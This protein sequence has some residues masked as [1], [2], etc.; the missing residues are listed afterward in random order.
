MIRKPVF[1]R[2]IGLIGLYGGVFVVLVMIQ[3]AKQGGF[4]QQVGSLLITGQYR[5]PEN[6]EAN[7]EAAANVG[8]YPL[9][10]GAKVFFGG[11]EFFMTGGDK[12]ESLILID[13]GGRKT[14]V[15]P[16]YMTIS[17]ETAG[18]HLP[19]GNELLFF[20]QY[21]GG[22][23]ELRISG[24]FA[25]GAV[26]ISL[27]YKPLRSSRV[28]EGEDDQLVVTA[29]G[30]N[31]TF[32]RAIQDDEPGRLLL[33]AGGASI[34]YR[35]IPEKRA[36]SPT[37]F[38]IPAART[39]QAYNEALIRWRDQNFSL[40]NRVVP[41][42]ND[43]DMVIAYEGEAVRRGN[44]K[45]ALAAVPPA[46]LGGAQRSYES[47]VYLGGMDMAARTFAAAEREKI[48][49]LS[50]QINEKSLDFLREANVFEFFAIRGYTNFMDGGSALIHAIDPA[51][52]ALELTA[53]I[54]EGVVDLWRRRP[55]GDNPFE[56]LVDQSCFIISEG[57]RRCAVPQAPAGSSRQGAEQA[58]P[59]IPGTDMILVFRDGAA[60]IEFN[61]RLGKALLAWAEASGQEDWIALG[62]SLILSCLSLE[63]SFGMIPAG[64]HINEAGE[65]AEGGLARINSARFYRILQPGEYYPR[66][67]DIVPGQNGI[68]AWTA[69]SAISATQN[70][71]ILDIAVTF[72]VGEAHHMIIRGIRPF[73]KLQLYGIDF[74]TDPQF[75]RYDSSGWVYQPQEQILVLKMKHRTAVEH[76][77]IF[78]REEQAAVPERVITP[79]PPR[80]TSPG[81]P[82]APPAVPGEASG[83]EARPAAPVFGGNE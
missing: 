42:Q 26:G 73:A 7:A 43:E 59:G 37:D 35:A 20:T 54:L 52:L 82:A 63:D 65:L 31:Y 6:G 46:F 34:A 40:W 13:A 69:V 67:A 47:S 64:M 83:G 33:R 14:E 68:W 48:S 39:A 62:R 70:D 81:V 5:V 36:F 76:I 21:I 77:R 50:R 10:D 57:I 80:G 41:F 4:N 45:A 79:E 66:V 51:S 28:R 74:R 2:L 3:F 78:T 71:N 29:E 30:L 16:E 61:L 17:G 60:D 56:R 38:I 49:R 19:G 15:F 18:F 25:E 9:A 23:P 53:G 22:T 24:N 44:Y 58:V 11:I 72:P 8:E 32:G 1:P 75:E 12:D 27:P 55:R